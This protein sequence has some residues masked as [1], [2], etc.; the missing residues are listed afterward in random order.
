ML[1]L[2]QSQAHPS[3]ST[4]RSYNACCLPLSTQ[5]HCSMTAHLN[6]SAKQPLRKTTT[7]SLTPPLRLSSL[8][9]DKRPSNTNLLFNMACATRRIH[10]SNNAYRPKRLDWR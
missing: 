2:R 3:P 4:F 9:I 1:P 10:S 6:T 8:T 7:V 5:P